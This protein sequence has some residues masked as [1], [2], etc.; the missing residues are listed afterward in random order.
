M[1]RMP[2][3]RVATF[4][5]G[6][7]GVAPI[8]GYASLAASSEA[9]PAGAY[10]T[11][12]TFGGR[13]VLRLAAHLRRLEEST[14]LQGR[15]GSVDDA[16]ARRA[17]A[18][19]LDATRHP[20]SRVRLTF[21]PPR[22]FVAVESFESL[23]ARLYA[24]GVACVTLALHR[25]NPHSKDTRFIATAQQAYARLP[26]GVEE[27]LLVAE[28]GAVL[29]GLSSNFFAVRTG[30]LWTEEARVLA[31]VTRSL[32]LEVAAGVLPVRREAVRK[33]ALAHLEE[34]FVTS[35]SREVLPVTRIDGGRIGDGRVG[36][37]TR[38]IMDAFAA[39]VA[40][41]REEL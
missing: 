34:A 8:G 9:L 20:E 10:T 28:D 12:R 29:E 24:D 37:R 41:E 5:S 21:A 27:G 11:F 22:L 30:E 3:P 2:E 36:P 35:V 15:P 32:V 18:E 40:H 14:A 23:P 17:I 38:A 33:D 6:P 1:E 7:S 39:L 31:G 13:G 26:E 19:A 25:E 4:E 16:A